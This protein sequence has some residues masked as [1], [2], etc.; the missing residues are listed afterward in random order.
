MKDETIKEEKIKT[1]KNDGCWM[2]MILLILFGYNGNTNERLSK[3]EG[4][5]E[6]IEN[7]LK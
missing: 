7:L 5:V 1:E 2:F 6:I 4:K 3:L